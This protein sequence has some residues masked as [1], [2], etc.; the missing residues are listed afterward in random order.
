MSVDVVATES[1]ALTRGRRVVE[2]CLQ[3]CQAYG[4]TDLAGRLD[5]ARKMLADPTAHIVVAGEFKQGKSSLVNA[6]LGTTVCPV[7]D[8]V[9]TAV[10]TYLRHGDEQRAALLLEGPD[11]EPPVRRPIDLDDVRAHVMEKGRPDLSA[12][13][14]IGVEIALP[15]QMLAGGLVIVD[16]P[17]VGG[18]GSAH[19]AGSLAAISMADAVVFVTDASQELTRSELDFVRQA[20]DLCRTVVC[21]LTKTD[22]YPAWR[23]VRELNEGHLRAVPGVGILTVSSSLR[24]LAVKNGDKA[25]NAESGFADLVRFVGERVGSGVAT[26]LATEAAAD[27]LAVCDQITGQ[28]EAERAALADPAAAQRII[29]ELSRAKERV[30]H[31]RS[32]SA[33]WSQTLND[34]IADLSASTTT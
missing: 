16:T 4:R 32:A 17:G 31:L 27:V 34:G 18:L 21:V 24:A 1:A 19:A 20:N 33:K 30:E 7:D 13:R 25:V 3:A 29:D 6:L 22:F 8:D 15:R 23:R 5:R 12:E 28:F 2:L 26:R 10:P 11:G 9:A 14:I